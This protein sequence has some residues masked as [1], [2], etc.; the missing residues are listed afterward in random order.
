MRKLA[1]ATVML[2]AALAASADAKTGWRQVQV[3]PSSYA[4]RMGPPTRV[5][6]HDSLRGF[7]QGVSGSHRYTVGCAI[8]RGGRCTIH[9]LR[10]APREVLLHEKAHCRGW[11]H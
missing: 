7:C 3:P 10:S 9:L 11:Q 1:A 4:W 2:L 6:Y 8:R 5:F